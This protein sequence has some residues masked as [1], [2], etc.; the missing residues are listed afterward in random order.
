MRAATIRQ[1]RYNSMG[2]WKMRTFAHKQN[3]PQKPASSSFA[4]SDTAILGLNHHANP[5]LPLQ[6]TIGNHAMRWML[7]PQAEE[8]KAG[9]SGTASPLFGHDFSRIPIH[10]PTAAIQTKLAINKP[11]N[12]YEQEADRVLTNQVVAASAHT[13]VS[14]ALPH[15]QRFSGQSNG[16]MDAASTSVDQALASPGRLLESALRQDTEQRF[17]HDFGSGCERPVARLPPTASPSTTVIQPKLK[18]GEPNDTFE[19][20][21]D[22]VADKIM[23]M[24]G[25]LPPVTAISTSARVQPASAIQPH[26]IEGVSSG[27]QCP[28]CAEKEKIENETLTETTTA[29]IQRK[30]GDVNE[31]KNQISRKEEDKKAELEFHST[32]AFNRTESGYSP[33]GPPT[34]EGFAAILIRWA[35]WNTG[36]KTAPE[37]VD[38]LTIY[39]ADRCSGCRDEKDEILTV[40]VTAPSIVSITQ[41]DEGE[42]EY[43]GINHMIGMTIRAGHYDVYVDLDV[44]DEVEEINEDNNTAFMTFYV[45]PRN[46][47]EPD[48]EG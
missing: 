17:G 30:P 1:Q 4:R 31:P 38:R 46:K 27:G 12:E 16:Q 24:P 20:E 14:G 6:R 9:L 23:Q 36:W 39:K 18:V 29:L 21:A 13:G 10:P 45:K 40:D 28:R 33:T 35:V 5:L 8:L 37:H 22:R 44:Y 32:V 3:Q 15:I 47:S 34:E 43:E 19:Q 41:P 42:S 11:G 26:C 25:A 2:T 7:Q 48:T